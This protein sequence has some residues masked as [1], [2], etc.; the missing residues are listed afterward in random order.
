MLLVGGFGCLELCLYGIREN[1]MIPTNESTVFRWILTNE[2]APLYLSVESV[3]HQT[4]QMPG[5]AA[6]SLAPHGVPL[7]G[8]SAGANLRL[9]EGFLQLLPAGQQ[10]DVC[11]DLVRTGP[12]AAETRHH[13]TVDLKIFHHFEALNQ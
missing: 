9:L 2:S 1:I 8:H 6:H 12:E 13:L 11:A 5:Q 10:S 4:H 3:A 7:V